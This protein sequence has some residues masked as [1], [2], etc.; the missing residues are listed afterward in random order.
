MV[1]LKKKR[2]FHVLS[3]SLSIVSLRQ[4]GALNPLRF[5]VKIG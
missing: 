3:V 2:E 5:V 1:D 4:S